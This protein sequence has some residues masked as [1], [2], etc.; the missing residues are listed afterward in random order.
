MPFVEGESLRQHIDRS[1]P[2]PLGE[3]VRLLAGDRGRAGL[4]PPAA[5]R[6]PRPQARQHP[7]GR[8]PRP[9]HRLRHRQ[10]ALGGRR[11]AAR[12][13]GHDVHRPGPGDAD[14]HGA[15][16]GGGRSDRPPRGSLRARMRGVRAADRTAALPRRLGAGADR[17]PHRR[18]ARAGDGPSAR[19]AGGAGGAGDASPGQA[20][21]RPAG[22][23]GC[24]AEGPSG[25][26]DLRS[27]G[28]GSAR[29]AAGPARCVARAAGLCLGGSRG[30]RQRRHSW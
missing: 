8:R 9:H 6:P 25:N 20:A 24:S 11:G 17:G 23:G 21:G 22:V 13:H 14:L 30:S 15:G 19:G 3:A 1:G 2:L 16:A 26:R 10:G 5:D 12:E 28:G 18:R 27:S 4:R 7:A 29:A